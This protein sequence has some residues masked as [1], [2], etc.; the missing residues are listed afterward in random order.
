MSILSISAELAALPPSES[1]RYDTAYR[2][3]GFEFGFGRGGAYPGHS[4][5]RFID[6]MFAPAGVRLSSASADAAMPTLVIAPARTYLPDLE[7]GDFTFLKFCPDDG[8]VNPPEKVYEKLYEQQILSF[9][10]D[11]HVTFPFYA[12]AFGERESVEV[13]LQGEH[14][15]LSIGSRH[16]LKIQR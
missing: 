15:S 12:R 10:D 11:A 16:L 13:T 4:H 3:V 1:K 5:L 8:E 7:T 9:R 14:L 2:D 6:V